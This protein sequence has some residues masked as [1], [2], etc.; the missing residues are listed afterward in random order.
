MLKSIVRCDSSGADHRHHHREGS[1]RTGQAQGNTT[2]IITCWSPSF[3][4]TPAALIT[5]IITEGSLRTGQA[6]VNTTT[7]IT[8][9]SPSFDVTPA[10]LITGIITERGVYAPDKLK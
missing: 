5:G 9:W 7:I 10:A 1:L 6:Q 4:V 8:C 3:D 2:T